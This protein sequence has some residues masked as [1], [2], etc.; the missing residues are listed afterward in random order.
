MMNDVKM[1]GWSNYETWLIAMHWVD[2]LSNARLEEQDETG[3]Q[4]RW[5]EEQI[6]DLVWE[7]EVAMSGMGEDS[8]CIALTLFRNAWTVINWREIAEIVNV[9]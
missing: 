9:D 2:Y 6:K 8:P 7:S 3:E 1:N 4:I 5:T